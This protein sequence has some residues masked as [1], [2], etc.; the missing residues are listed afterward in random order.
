MEGFLWN[1]LFSL[2]EMKKKYWIGIIK[3]PHS[4][5]GKNY[6]P[7]LYD[8]KEYANEKKLVDQF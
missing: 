8:H 7:Q 4:T 3:N 5:A 6:D 2:V 1:L